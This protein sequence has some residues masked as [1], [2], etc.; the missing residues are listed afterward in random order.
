MMNKLA[1]QK[2]FG[3]PQEK[4][5]PLF[6]T[7][8]RLAEQKGVD[9][10][11]GALA[12]MLSADIQFVLLGS[13]ATAYERGYLELAR[14]FPDKVAVHVGYDERLAHR[15][16]AA[17]DFYLMP[18][19]FEPSGLNQMYSL[20]YG[21]IPVVRATGGLDDS[22]VD[23]TEDAQRANGIKFREY[24]ARALAKAIRKALAIYQQPELLRRYRQNAM[25]MDFSWKRTVGNYLDVY[26][27]AKR[28]A[29]R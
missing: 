25:K 8:S 15:I 12:E 23:W 24:S 14:R 5:I 19:R 16:E 4:T 22:V 6:G 26:E 9:I 27:P 20:R 29:A 7:I 13:G 3:L 18:S 11:L 17:S 28:S 1:L 10:Q 2:E 21:A